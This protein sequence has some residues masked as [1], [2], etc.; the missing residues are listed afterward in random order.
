M[1]AITYSSKDSR[2]RKKVLPKT[3]NLKLDPITQN[4]QKTIVWEH[5]KNVYSVH[6]LILRYFEF[7][8]DWIYPF[9]KG[10]SLKPFIEWCWDSQIASHSCILSLDSTKCHLFSLI[11]SDNSLGDHWVRFPT[12]ITWP[13]SSLRDLEQPMWLFPAPERTVTNFFIFCSLVVILQRFDSENPYSSSG[14]S[15]TDIPI[16]EFVTNRS[17]SV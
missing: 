2:N 17:P 4:H 15:R 13:G 5:T 12:V 9:Y 6:F 7:W 1:E 16:A 11:L 14:T 8:N 3:Q 10:N